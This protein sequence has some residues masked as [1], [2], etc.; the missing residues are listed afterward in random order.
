[1]AA[2]W[3]LDESEGTVV[4]DIAGTNDAVSFGGPQWQPTG[5]IVDGAIELDG[6]DDCVVAGTNPRINKGPFSVL[7]WVRGGSMG[8]VVISQIGGVNWL[9]ACPSDGNLMTEL[10]G[11]GRGGEPLRSQMSITDGEWHRIGLVWNGS[12]RKL[13]VDGI[14]AAEDTQDSLANSDGGLYI[15]CGNNMGGGTFW[16]GLIDD[17]RIY[18]RVVQP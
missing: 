11:S 7:A 14:T 16:S 15:G 3:S 12:S 1:M 5:G 2:H 18:D 10:R 8:Q 6:V 4:G 13:Y 17:V 9:L